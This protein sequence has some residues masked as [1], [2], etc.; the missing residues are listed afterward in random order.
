M[1]HVINGGIFYTVKYRLF[2][3]VI[4]INEYWTKQY[5]CIRI[6]IVLMKIGIL[7]IERRRNMAK[8]IDLN[9]PTVESRELRLG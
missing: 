3:Y 4:L 6:V 2:L 5:N 7:P 9:L 8:R 1:P